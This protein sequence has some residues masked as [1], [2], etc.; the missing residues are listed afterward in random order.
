MDDVRNRLVTDNQKLIHHWLHRKGIRT[1]DRDYED[2]FQV[3]NVGLSIAAIKHDEDKSS[4]SNYASLVIKSVISKERLYQRRHAVP[5]VSLEDT[6]YVN[7][8]ELTRAS[9]IPDDTAPIDQVLGDRERIMKIV[10]IILNQLSFRESVSLLASISKI[11]RK[12][13]AA[14][15]GFSDNAAT[16]AAQRARRK[17]IE[18]LSSSLNSAEYQWSVEVNG[19]ILKIYRDHE[20][21]VSFLI[22][23]DLWRELAH[24][25]INNNRQC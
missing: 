11:P 4:F 18:A 22:T 20:H 25:L 21:H 16:N 10:S 13:Y 23:D 3:G 14:T 15:L 9:V 7:N 17:L 12:Q 6:I 1:G 19:D 5:S 8:H 2:Y 24:W